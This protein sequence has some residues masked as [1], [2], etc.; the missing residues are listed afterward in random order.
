M[1]VD[2]AMIDL[3]MME[4]KGLVGAAL[5]PVSDVDA[6][7]DG[8]QA[9]TV[10]FALQRQHVFSGPSMCWPAHEAHYQASKYELGSEKE[11][12]DA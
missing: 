7:L 2:I 10:Q 3:R 9:I 11:A 8:R 6:M 12:A 4:I 5:Q 1:P